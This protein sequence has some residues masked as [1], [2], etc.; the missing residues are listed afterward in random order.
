MS[1]G[2]DIEETRSKLEKH[3]KEHKQEIQKNR[4]RASREEAA[5][6]AMLE[7]EKQEEIEKRRQALLEDL[8]QKKMKEDSQQKMLDELV[9]SDKSAQDVIA[10]HSLLFT[11]Q[12]EKAK[13]LIHIAT[14]TGQE[15]LTPMELENVEDFSYK[16]FVAEPCGP[17]F[18]SS[19]SL[20]STGYLK[21]VRGLDGSQLACGYSLQI[22][23][24]RALQDALSGLFYSAT[25]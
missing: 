23:C 18:P 7:A 25:I 13:K 21:Y 8:Q 15:H 5:A 9:I 4:V 16:P 3:K 12:S 11:E 22:A 10:A 6:I 2:I 17:T 20:E 14:I 19:D 1:N 24:Q